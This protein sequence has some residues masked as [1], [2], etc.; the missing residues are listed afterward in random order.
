[1]PQRD[2]LIDALRSAAADV[3]DHEFLR[4]AGESFSYRAGL[5]L[6]E[7]TARGLLALGVE[8]GDR[9]GLMCDNR[10][11]VAWM[12][13][14]TNAARAIDVPFN[15]DARGRMLAY[16]VD[17]AQPRVLI[18]T[19]DY[20]TILAESITHDPEVVV[21][22]GDSAERP[23]GDR[24]R[25]ISFEELVELG[26]AHGGELPSP[27]PGETATIMYTSGTTG[28]SKGVMLPQRYYTAQAA[29][30]TN[31]Y[32]LTHED[33]IYCVQ[34]LFHID[35]RAFMST[36]VD[37]R[38]T[39]V[40]GRRFSASRFWDEVRAEGATAFGTIGTMLW[41]LYKQ[42]ARP[43]DS[44]H[45]ARLAMCSSTPGDIMRE[46]E[47]RFDVRIIEAYG[48]TECVLITTA[49]PGESQP[50]RIGRQLPEVELQVVDDDDV[51]LEPGT[52]GELVFRPLEPF[53]MMQGYWNKPEA[54]VEAWRN[55]WFHTGDLVRQYP[56]GFLE[57]IGRKKDSIRR[58]G[59]NVS[60]WEVETAVVAHPRVLEA[61]AIGVPSDVG[62][63]DVAVL[64]VPVAG[65]ELDPAE[66]VEFVAADLPRFAVPR[67]V[68]LVD[69]LP[70]TPSE[71][72]EKGKVR[73]RGITSAAWDSN[74]AL[75]RR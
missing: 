5:E 70:K 27:G 3:P 56:D 57:Y 39:A 13:F 59:E 34:P 31:T 52:V 15:A 21:C 63:E 26:R 53:A 23:F 25:Q 41:L 68:E 20:L 18:A 71:R 17:D 47:E 35:A 4:I 24:A 62:E 55:L 30:V 67:Y 40:L 49:P 9:V 29:H 43:D 8:A 37:L 42:P 74:L 45:P 33:V 10:A 46:F 14:G 32:G 38:A 65:A 50:R 11:E 61:A 12:W 48:M 51:P 28:P 1:M 54:T 69:S 44:D 60:C 19:P 16:F 64:V 58:R 66:L 6:V 73:E 36:V 7:S 2:S 72:I 75:G 22:V